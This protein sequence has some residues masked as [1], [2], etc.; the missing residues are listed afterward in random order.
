LEDLCD[1]DNIV[2]DLHGIIAAAKV[3]NLA[4]DLHN[5]IRAIGLDD[6]TEN[7]KGR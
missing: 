3:D 2:P 6:L 1:V 7:M 5:I 4:T